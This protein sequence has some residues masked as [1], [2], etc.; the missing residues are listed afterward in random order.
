MKNFKSSSLQFYELFEYFLFSHDNFYKILV[1]C[2]HLLTM[3]CQ[4]C[5]KHFPSISTVVTINVHF[6]GSAR[7]RNL[8]KATCWVKK[9]DLLQTQRSTLLTST[10]WY[11]SQIRTQGCFP[12]WSGTCHYPYT[13]G[14]F[15]GC[16]FQMQ[17]LKREEDYG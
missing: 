2:Y 5:A 8:P 1:Y 3:M 10:L 4:H 17:T 15:I 7:L 13:L 14:P 11:L 6:T 9:A 12:W 16:S